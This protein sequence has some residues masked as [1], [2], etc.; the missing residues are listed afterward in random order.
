MQSRKIIDV[1]PVIAKLAEMALQA[2]GLECS[3]LGN[4]IDM[5]RAAPDET[6]T[7]VGC[8][9]ISVRERLPDTQEYDWVLVNIRLMPEN[10]DGVPCVA[11]LRNGSWYDALNGLLDTSE[12]GCGVIVTHWMPLPTPPEEVD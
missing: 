6:D 8:K 1:G 2:K 11:E 3:L 12:E 4:V 10:Y 5:L 7:N 9:W